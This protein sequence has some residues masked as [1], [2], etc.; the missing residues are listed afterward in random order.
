MFTYRLYVKNLLSSLNRCGTSST[1][2]VLSMADVNR[3]TNHA[4][5]YWYIGSMLAKSAAI[6]ADIRIG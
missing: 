1:L 5:L 4:K 6:N 2:S 3:F